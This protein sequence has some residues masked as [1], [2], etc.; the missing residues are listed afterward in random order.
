MLPEW[1]VVGFSGHRKLP[2]PKV[3]SDAIRK[4]FDRLAANHSPL[5]SVSS[6]ASGA[7]TLFVEEVARRNLP[8]LLV[9]PFPKARFQQDFSPADWQR[10]LPFI[11]NATRVEEV[12]GEESAERAYMEAGVLTADRADVMVVVWDGKPAAGF[13]GTGDVVAYVRELRK[14]LIIIDPNSGEIVEERLEQLPAKSLPTGGNESPHVTVGQHFQEL[15]ETAQLHAPQSRHL[16]LRIILFQ[17]AA[18]AIGFIALAFEIHGHADELIML[19]ELILLGI[20]FALSLHH[21]KKHQEWMKNRIAAEICRSFLA[22]WHMRRADYSPKVSIEGFDRLCRNLRLIRVLD[23]T[24][25]PSLEAVRD[26]YLKERVENQIAYF[27]RHSGRA[28]QIYGKLKAFALFS[29]ATAALLSLLALTFSF[30]NFSG[31]ALTVPKYLSLLLPLASAAI[32]SLM[33]TQDYSRRAVRYGEMAS[34]LEDAARR[35]K[36]VRTWN[37]LARIATETEEA[38]L[39]EVVE[40]HSFRQFAGEPH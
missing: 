10:I 32:F 25:P 38:L 3:A 40:W 21:R 34:M 14:P 18:S 2:D 17:L 28:R 13:G 19:A 8:C 24:Q 36:M 31:L 23:K 37:S 39:Q 35:L 20:A 16:V 12:A 29:T 11:E 27:S 6:A 7:D 4:V 26:Q 22:T 1:T 9:L 30:W 33:I 5:A 15:D